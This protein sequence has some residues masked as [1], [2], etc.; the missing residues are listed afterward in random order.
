[1]AQLDRLGVEVIKGSLAEGYAPVGPPLL[2]IPRDTTTYFERQRRLHN[3]L[4]QYFGALHSSFF[5]LTFL[6]RDSARSLAHRPLRACFICRYPIDGT[7]PVK[8]IESGSIELTPESDV[9]SIKCNMLLV[10]FTTVSHARTCPCQCTTSRSRAVALNRSPTRSLTK[11]STTCLVLGAWCT[12]SEYGYHARRLAHVRSTSRHRHERVPAIQNA[13][14]NLCNRCQRNKR[15]VLCCSPWE[16]S[17]VCRQ[18]RQPLLEEVSA[19]AAQDAIGFERPELGHCSSHDQ[20]GIRRGWL[21]DLHES[22]FPYELHAD[23]LWR[24]ILPTTVLL[25]V[26]RRVGRAGVLWM[27]LRCTCGL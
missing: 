8:S 9:R 6:I 14:R 5:L 10:A 3:R 1:M 19:C 2:C 26:L 15:R 20:A 4:G 22:P 11:P 25:P 7:S 24:A 18:E 21:P 17:Q 12:G 23:V 13:T 16:P 27:V